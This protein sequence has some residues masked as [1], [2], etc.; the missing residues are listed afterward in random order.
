MNDLRE[1]FK[2]RLKRKKEGLEVN[3]N[4]LS[5][6]ES[7]SKEMEQEIENNKTLKFKKS[8]SEYRKNIDIKSNFSELFS[9]FSETKELIPEEFPEIISEKEEPELEQPNLDLI[10][11]AV[12]SISKEESLKTQ[13]NIPENYTNLFTNPEVVRIDPNIKSIQSKLKI[14]EEWVSKI[15]MTG[16]GGGSGSILDLDTPV[17]SVDSDYTMNR[18]DYCLL[19]NPSVKTYI[20]LPP[21]YD[22]RK[23]V[24]KDISGHAQLTP[25]KINGTIDGDPNGAE[26]RVN[27]AALQL[28]YFNNSWWII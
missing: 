19:V 13:D 24:I 11:I 22:E 21:A 1:D 4:P 26:I 16:P 25:I 3:S 27:Y 5:L 14:L 28:I 20:N 8:L 2:E 6:F 18:K 23:V 10:S 15:S 17:V 12:Q 7:I 9:P